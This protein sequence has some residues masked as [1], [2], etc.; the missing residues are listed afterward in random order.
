MKDTVKSNVPEEPTDEPPASSDDTDG[1][2]DYVDPEELRKTR[3]PFASSAGP[4]RITV[5]K[6]EKVPAR[7]R[8]KLM[9]IWLQLGNVPAS[10]LASRTTFLRK[11]SNVTSPAES[12]PI[13]IASVILRHLH[14]VLEK[15]LYLVL[16]PILDKYQ[17]G[18]RTM[19]G[20][21]R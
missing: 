14:K 5:G 4:D 18:F 12:R 17:F 15:R 19:D 11:K 3:L 6:W 7:A 9:T 20:I 16:D 13:S 21:D 8:C 10:I 1:L 2:M